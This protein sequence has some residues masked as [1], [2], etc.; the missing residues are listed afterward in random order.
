[1]NRY[2]IGLPARR[3]SPTGTKDRLGMLCPACAGDTGVIDTRAADSNTIRRRRVCFA[4]GL[5]LTT[6]ETITDNPARGTE[7]M[8]RQVAELR[9]IAERIEQLLDKPET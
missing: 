3:R 9:A 7:R 8:R 5:R 6:Y 4:C 1:M 2:V